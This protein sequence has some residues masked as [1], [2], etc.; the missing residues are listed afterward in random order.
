MSSYIIYTDGS[1]LG[2]PGPGGWAAHILRNGCEIGDL[3]GSSAATSNNRME[4]QAAMEAISWCLDNAAPGDRVELKLD[5]EYTR[6][7]LFEWLPNWRKRSMRKANGKPVA[8][9]DL[10]SEA[11]SL[12]DRATAFGITLQGTWVKGHANEAGNE[13]VDALARRAAE[14]EQGCGPAGQDGFAKI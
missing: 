9:A 1:C 14:L 3:C 2:N 8:N 13:R 5:S 6:N 11:A 12:L 4:L 7:G 10:W